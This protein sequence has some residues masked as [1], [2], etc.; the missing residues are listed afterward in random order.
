MFAGAARLSRFLGYIVEGTCR[1]DAD[2]LKEFVI[3]TDVFDR[4][5]RYDPRLD[6]VVRVEAGRLRSKLAEYYAGPGANDP[7]VI[8][9][10]RGGYVPVIEPAAPVAAPPLS[11]ASPAVAPGATTAGA[12]APPRRIPRAMWWAAGIGIVAIAGFAAVR[13]DAR[14]SRPPAPRAVSVAVLPL[15]IASTDE[16]LRSRATEVTEGITRELARLGTV[17]VVS[18][19]TAAQAN[20]RAPLPEIGRTL[21][22]SVVVSGNVKAE[23]NAVRVQFIVMDAVRDRK[24]LVDTLTGSTTDLADLERRVAEAIA[25]RVVAGPSE[26]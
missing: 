22:A 14:G 18:H 6:S 20:T 21:G 12:P 5:A 3:G 11:V 8:T 7:I 1:G 23:A 25:G 26:P 2:Q 16:A 10:P 4:D 24:V 17:A 9:V 19:I 15:S 13:G